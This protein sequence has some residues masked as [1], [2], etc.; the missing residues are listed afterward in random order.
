MMDELINKYYELDHKYVWH[1]WRQKTQIKE[2]IIMVKGEGCYVTDIEGKVYLDATSSALNASCGYNNKEIIEEII[3]QITKLMN[4]DFSRFSTI[5][6]IE[7][8]KKIADLL[9]K[10][11]SRTFFCNS[12]SEAVEAAIKMARMY[13]GLTQN[14]KKANVISL[15]GGYHGTTMA[16]ISASHSNFIQEGNSP[17]PAGFHAIE[18]PICNKCLEFIDHNICE[19]PNGLQL[20]EKILELGANTVAA[21]IME[22]IMGIG[23][24]IIPSKQFVKKIEEICNKYNI[25]LIFDETMTSFG[26]TGRMFAFQHFDVIPDIL[27]CGKGISG[28]YFP[29]S[30]ITVSEKVYKVFSKDKCLKGFRHGH[31]N[32]GHSTGATAAL[33]TIKTIEKN[34]LVQNSEQ[35]GKFLLEELQLLQTKYNFIN[36]LRGLGLVV[37]INFRDENIC[38]KIVKMCFDEGLIVRQAGRALGI[39]PPLLISKEQG[40]EIIS[41]IK[42]VLDGYSMMVKENSC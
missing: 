10:K 3:S 23:G 14:E 16:A 18:K 24:F 5:P 8:A 38:E 21:F 27:I 29:M 31:T 42:K 36:N 13:S 30:T 22:P 2:N 26:R 4:F 6:A 32:S 15:Q 40:V 37:A 39:I 17:M 11:L 41:I 1:P 33:A 19:I 28:G 9:P 34:N 20:E 7:L 35:V 12:G 25:L